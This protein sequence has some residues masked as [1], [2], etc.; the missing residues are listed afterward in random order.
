[1]IR[2]DINI[3]QIAD[4]LGLPF[5][6]YDKWKCIVIGE[7][8]WDN[9]GNEMELVLKYQ[10]GAYNNEWKRTGISN[11]ELH[12]MIKQTVA[13][14]LSMSGIMT[15]EMAFTFIAGLLLIKKDIKAWRANYMAAEYNRELEKTLAALK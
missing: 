10:H 6:E 2:E 4:T 8:D 1:M 7:A 11:D 12:V 13:G 5:Y 9:T 14:A 3:E 15:N